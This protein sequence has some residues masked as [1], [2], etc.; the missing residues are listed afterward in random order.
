MRLRTY[1]QAG[2]VRNSY[3]HLL[4]GWG[5]SRGPGVRG[6]VEEKP[7]Y[8]QAE[9]LVSPHTSL[10]SDWFRDR[11]G[12]AQT[13]PGSDLP[14]LPEGGVNEVVC[15]QQSWDKSDVAVSVDGD[16]VAAPQRKRDPER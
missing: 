4:S 3:E 7:I 12:P 10:N 6:V 8:L 11:Q 1:W 9:A 16:G 13:R 5:I 15:R 2:L 14:V